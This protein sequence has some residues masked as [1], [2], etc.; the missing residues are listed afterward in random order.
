MLSKQFFLNDAALYNPFGTDYFLWVDGDLAAEIGDPVTQ[1]TDECRRNL[2]ALLGGDRMLYVGCPTDSDSDAPG[3]GR[4]AMAAFATQEPGYFVRG[5]IFG[6]TRRNI[7][8]INA[9]YYNCLGATL[10]AGHLGTEEQVL[11]ITSY[12]HRDLCHVQRLAA[13]RPL[14]TF[15]DRLQH[16]VPDQAEHGSLNR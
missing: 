12:T 11:T 4:S 7:H 2:A 1:F 5:R 8:A 15:F 13:Q 10:D 9:A 6:G 3:F 14:H 16:G